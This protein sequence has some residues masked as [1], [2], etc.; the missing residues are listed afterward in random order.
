MPV[1]VA[2]SLALLSGG[3]HA[4]LDSS[5]F[6]SIASM[7]VTEAEAD[8][9]GNDLV[10]SQSRID[11]ELGFDREAN[12]F[13][14]IDLGQHR[15]MDPVANAGRVI[16]VARELVA[17]GED[18]YRLVQKGRPNVTS[19]YAPLSIVPNEN[20]RAV[21]PMSLEY[22]RGPKRQTWTVV[23]K[24]IYGMAVVTLRYSAVFNCGGSYNGKGAYITNAQIIPEY[25]NVLFGFDYD[26]TMRVAG[27]QNS[28]SRQDPIAGATLV[29]SHSA[30]SVMNTRI[31]EEKIFISGRGQLQKF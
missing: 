21:D 22:M 27:I 3:A 4:A 26:V 15:K 24:N 5:E 28:G 19:T 13:T 14:Y 12:S 6:Y 17:L 23:Y 16:G 11:Y 2:L 9:L 1:T 10:T 29:L 7:E 20:G 18:I 30:R 31:S 25:I 8:A